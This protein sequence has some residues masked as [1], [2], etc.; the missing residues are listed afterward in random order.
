VVALSVFIG[1]AN[2]K[3][4]ILPCIFASLNDVE[5]FVI[6]RAVHALTALCQL[7]MLDKASL[8]DTITN[9]CPLLCHPRYNFALLTFYSWFSS[10]DASVV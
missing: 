10:N 9:L 2:F 6:Q 1:R 5:E 3:N 4:G 7:S 8:S